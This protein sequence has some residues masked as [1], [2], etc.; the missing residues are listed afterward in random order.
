MSIFDCAVQISDTVNS[1]EHPLVVL[2]MPV[3]HNSAGF[4]ASLPVAIPDERVAH[5]N[6]TREDSNS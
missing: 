2:F 5:L 3:K 6:R 1:V 4:E